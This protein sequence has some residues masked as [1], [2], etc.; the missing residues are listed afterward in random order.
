MRALILTVENPFAPAERR[1]TVLRRPRRIGS[2]MARHIR[3]RPAI[4]ILN[5]RPVLRQAWRRRLR[6]GDRLVIARLPM[7][8]GGGSNPLRTLL[9]LSVMA[10]APCAAAGLLGYGASAAGIAAM[11]GAGGAGLLGTATVA[12]LTLAGTALVNALMPVPQPGKG[13]TPSPTYT[14]GAQGNT[15]RLE[16]AIPVQYGRLLA[17]PDFAAQPYTEYAGNEQYLYQILCLGCGDYDIEE[18]RIED[19][20]ISAFTEI[21]TEIIPPGGQVT[22]F[23]TQVISSL[24]VSGQELLGEAEGTWIA[25]AS[26]TITITEPGHARALGQILHL[27]FT[28]GQTSGTYAVSGVIDAD[29]YTVL[30]SGTTPGSGDV[31]VRAVMGGDT[32]FIATAPG[33]IA[34]R[35]AV[36]IVLPLGLFKTN[37]S[38]NPKDLTLSWHVEAR[39]VD[40]VGNPIGGWIT[41][42][43]H[44]LT[45]RSATPIRLSYSYTLATPG[46]YAVRAWRT[47]AR[48][49]DSAAGHQIVWAG[50]RAYLAEAQDWGPVTLIAM[51]MRA[52][53]NLS[54][55]ASRKVGVLATRKLPVWTGTAWTAPQPTRSIALAIADAARNADYGAGLADSRIDLETLRTLDTL[56]TG[57]G[58]LFDGRF[59]TSGTWWDAV[60]RI[61]LTGRARCFMQGGRLRVVRDGPANVPVCAF[62]MRNIVRGSFVLDFLIPTQDDANAVEVSYLDSTTWAPRTVR[63]ALEGSTATR[64]AKLTLFGATGRNHALREGLYHAAASRYRRQIVKFATE[65]EGFI[66]ALGDLISIAHDMPGW[67]QTSEAVGWSAA[68]ATLTLADPPL[69]GTGDHVVSLRR[70]D[71]AASGPWPVVPGPT[72]RQVVFTEGSGITPDTG[73]ARE[74]THVM[75]GTADTWSALARVTSVRPRGLYEVEI[76]AVIE[77]PSVHTADAG[78]TAPPVSYSSLAATPVQPVVGNLIA[79]KLPGDATRALFSWAPAPGAALYQV[80]MAEGDDPSAPAIS[81]TPIADITQTSIALGL[82]YSART[83]IR[84]RGVGLAA[85]PWI[86]RTLGAL[87]P[88]FWNTDQTP[89]WTLDTNPMWSAA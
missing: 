28:G 38:G 49:E 81:W 15:A 43:D 59:D 60:T 63:A 53:N 19:T 7:G 23:P 32:G 86:A 46:R 84:V 68:T 35:L 42:G 8:G 48:I 69:W 65:M 82:L 51:R 77:D 47:D 83:M 5:G 54:L 45:D 80:E 17:Y 16:Q 12:G 75:F 31:I 50:L 78:A 4:A 39:R 85:G 61:A 40:D 72:D 6:D 14:L 36:D 41:L 52:T 89:M 74:R 20:P 62:S 37:A 71:G 44:A 66:P 30:R 10:F 64:P 26:T 88:D 70:R 73:A 18:M 27:T 55:Q 33:T 3:H 87:I 29:T 79:R 56:W 9:A 57:R 25:G 13:P 2:L 34:H 1:V 11:T 76:E 67:G 58:D 22:L 21:E 24:E